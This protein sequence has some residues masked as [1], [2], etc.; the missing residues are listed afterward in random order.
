MRARK[1]LRFAIFASSTEISTDTVF[2]SNRITGGS[3]RS[4]SLNEVE[5]ENDDTGGPL[6]IF[7]SYAS[8][9][10]N[11]AEPIAFSLRA[12]GHNVF[13]DRDDLPP[14]GE[15]DMRIESAIERSAL[16]VFL[17]SPS[18]I[19]K[20]K[21]TL[22]ELEFARRK[23]RNAD[24]HILP[25]MAK[26]VPLDE[27]PNL[28]KS[29]TVLEPQGN[30]AAEVAA[31]VDPLSESAA[32]GQM[33]FYAGMGLLSGLL[34]WPMSQALGTVRGLNFGLEIP[35]LADPLGVHG[36]PFNLFLSGLAFAIVLA[37]AFAYYFRFK[38]RQLVIVP[39][40]LASWFI[41]L[42]LAI[43]VG[44]TT[45]AHEKNQQC[46]QL[47]SGDETKMDPA[48]ANECLQFW[49]DAYQQSEHFQQDLAAWLAAGAIGAFGTAI[50]VP[51]AT[52]RIFSPLAFALTTV[53]G[54]VIAVAFYA[55]A[56]WTA[57]HQG[58]TIWYFLFAP[59]QAGVAA[60]IGR[61]IR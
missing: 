19:A 54:G 33:A 43:S 41:A 46:I 8:E 55:I 1:A 26:P 16:F 23:W 9:D 40:V 11:I 17:I 3:V 42:Q 4:A 32:G 57:P 10:K 53:A 60:V 20:G 13:F 51:F 21:F 34:T 2:R 59:W 30:M 27:V 47:Q 5:D 12:R 25:V 24:G 58:D 37:A 38:F 48:V 44:L 6:Q 36:V 28:L 61:S 18:S 14:G 56:S 35:G 52:R 49:R 29:V 31:A 15:Y 45:V 50:G 22:T 39:F 7:L